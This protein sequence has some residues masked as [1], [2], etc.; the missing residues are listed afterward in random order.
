M[1]A[2][3]QHKA[4][5]E[6]RAKM[7]S[8]DGKKLYQKRAGVEGTISQ[9]VRA[10]GLRQTRYIGLAKTH[11]QHLATAAAVNLA[12]INNWLKILLAR[13]RTSAFAALSP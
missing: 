8:E 13:T 2:E 7:E 9:G 6:I 10:F 5:S 4:L 1:H 3:K 12:R 11:L